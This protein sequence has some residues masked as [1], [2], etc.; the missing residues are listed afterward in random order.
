MI[1]QLF[2]ATGAI[3]IKNFVIIASFIA[4]PFHLY[5]MK[6]SNMFYC[7]NYESEIVQKVLK[8]YGDEVES[9]EKSLVERYRIPGTNSTLLFLAKSTNMCD[10]L[11]DTFNIPIEA[12]NRLKETAMHRAARD[13]RYNIACYL[14]HRYGSKQVKTHS[15][16]DL[17]SL[18]DLKGKT[19]LDYI[20]SE[21][22]YAENAPPRSQFSKET[23]SA[24]QKNKLIFWEDWPED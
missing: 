13:G 16:P 21:Y 18:R 20:P 8:D 17:F 24:R 2:K 4:A 15:L 19:A 23:C 10:I 6:T 3:L 14:I 7:E 11:L 22:L 1:S 12:T 5:C 9:L